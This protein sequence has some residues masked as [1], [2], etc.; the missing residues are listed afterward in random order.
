M[1]KLVHTAKTGA[2]KMF[3][4]SAGPTTPTTLAPFDPEIQWNPVEREGA[5]GSVG[6]LLRHISPTVR[7]WCAKRMSLET[8]K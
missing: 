1:D 4:N 3:S 2:S 5:I 6:T 7:L 8:D